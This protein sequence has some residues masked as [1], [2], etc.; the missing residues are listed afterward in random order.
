MKRE[1]EEWKGGRRRGETREKKV[2]RWKYGKGKW[3]IGMIKR[4]GNE[5]KNSRG[6]GVRGGEVYEPISGS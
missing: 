4:K 3:P 6:E 5:D 2:E 1:K